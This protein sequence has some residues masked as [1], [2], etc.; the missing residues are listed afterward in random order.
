MKAQPYTVQMMHQGGGPARPGIDKFTRE[1]AGWSIPEAAQEY[2]TANRG[3]VVASFAAGALVGWLARG[4][5]W[6]LLGGLGIAALV[7]HKGNK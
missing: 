6:W 7:T 4:S 2:L 3:K 5:F 1:A